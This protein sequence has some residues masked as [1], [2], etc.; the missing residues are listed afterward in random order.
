LQLT[1]KKMSAVWTPA[2]SIHHR[3]KA[4]H[5]HALVSRL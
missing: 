3:L 5:Q 1:V 4:R 2:R